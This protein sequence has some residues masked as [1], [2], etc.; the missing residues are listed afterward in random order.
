ML[1]GEI[2]PLTEQ[3]ASTYDIVCCSHDECRGKVTHVLCV[4]ADSF[5]A[6]CIGLCELHYHKHIQWTREEQI[7]DNCDLCG[8][9]RVVT[10]WRDP[11]EGA[12]G[13]VY[14]ICRQCRDEQSLISN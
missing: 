5:G 11:E 10:P 8:R 3:L 14:F 13:R 7:T 9:M 6:E 2:Y 1:P 12:S 4:D